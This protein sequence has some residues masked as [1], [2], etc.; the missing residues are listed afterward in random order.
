MASCCRYYLKLTSMQWYDFTGLTQEESLGAGYA[1]AIHK[2][3]LPMVLEM[4]DLHNKEGTECTSEAR[5]RRHDGFYKWMLIRATPCKDK[6]GNILKWYGTNT[7]IHDLIMDRITNQRKKDQVLTVLAHAEVNLFAVNQE[8]KIT[9]SEGGII[10]VSDG[11]VTSRSE[12]VGQDAIELAQKTQDGGI[13]EYEKNVKDILAGTVGL[14][15]SEDVVGNKV[16]RTRMVAELEHDPLDGAQ[17]PVVKGVL[18]LS[19]DIT[20]MKQRAALE[21]DNTRLMMEEQAAKDS[22]RMKSQFLANVSCAVP[23]KSKG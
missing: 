16:Y 22:N 14:A 17:L 8:Q 6:S 12:F 5:Y 11:R 2:D 15:S 20:D 18:G 7:E 3:D 19:I 21:L 4:W 13:P 1:Q 10:W 9:M 23:G